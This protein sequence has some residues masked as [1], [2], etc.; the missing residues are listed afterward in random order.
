M[1]EENL[2][3]G[4]LYGML[5]LFLVGLQPIILLARPTILDSYIF[6]TMATLFSTLFFLPF[7]L[8]EK[9]RTKKNNL[10]KSNKI[11]E[12]KFNQ[13]LI[14]KN[15]IFF[16]YLGA[17]FGFGRIFFYFGFDL[18]GATIGAVVSKARILIALF[19]GFIILKEKI[20]RNQVIFSLLL[21]LGLIIV[22]TGG[23]VENFELNMG[24]LILL[25]ISALW[26]LAHV[27]T[28]PIIENQEVSP[29]Y[30]VFIRSLLAFFVL[31]PT[32][33]LFFPAQNIFLLFELYN[34]FF[35]I[36]IGVVHG[37]GLY[38]WYKT[39]SYMR[40]SR[41]TMLFSPTPIISAFLAFF[42]LGEELTIF[43]LIGT[44]IVI[45][46]IILIMREQS[47]DFEE[48]A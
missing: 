29:L 36:S 13:G 22:I 47:Q 10:I 35:F 42:Y 4:F 31:F 5:G 33:F 14:R 32:Y 45:F 28:K 38:C 23:N 27:Q 16:L 3:R 39:L 2:K 21:L 12:K 26:T 6:A 46:S 18:V 24:I 11:K 20:N 7:I 34:L 15:F 17:V 41:A 40:F 19:F 9:N 1:L 44:L 37:C 48:I 43:T 30:I 25:G 8:M